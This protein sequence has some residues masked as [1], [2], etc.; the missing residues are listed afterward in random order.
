MLKEFD[1]PPSLYPPA[2]ELLSLTGRWWVGHTKARF[3]KSFAWDLLARKIPYF[4]PMV[5][6]VHASAG[7]KWKTL[8]P[9]FAS[10]VFFNGDDIARANALTTNRLCQV[11]RVVNQDELVGELLNIHRVI[12]AGITLQP[13]ASATVGSR[14]RVIRGPLQGIEGTL[15]RRNHQTRFVLHV[16]VLGQDAEL[17]I[18]PDLLETI[19]S[20]CSVS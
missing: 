3:E 16:S 11:V 2:A 6:R 1:N 7:R 8:V 18:E 14:C 4:L 9:L 15:I 20:V 10:Y 5:Q 19:E 12:Q 17:E 13:L